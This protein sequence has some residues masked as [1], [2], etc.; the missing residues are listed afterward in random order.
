[1]HKIHVEKS[2]TINAGAEKVKSIITEFNHWKH[3]S[4]WLILEP[5]CK[6]T[7]SANGK[8]QEWD[9][10]RIGAG[11]MKILS[12]EDSVIN[13]DL[14]FLKPWKPSKPTAPKLM[15]KWCT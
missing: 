14:T 8:M 12:E 13:Y 10:Q 3:W 1:M 5:E 9:G 15:A 11:N 7:V 4:P 2:I 6:V